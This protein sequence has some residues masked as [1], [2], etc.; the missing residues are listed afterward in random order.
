[1]ASI[2]V[3]CADGNNAEENAL[4]WKSLF[5]TNRKTENPTP[6]PQQNVDSNH[7]KGLI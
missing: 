7:T 5:D 4:N 2:R 6:S 1:M 3:M